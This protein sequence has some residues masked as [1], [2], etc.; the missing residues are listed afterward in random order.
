VFRTIVRLVGHVVAILVAVT[1]FSAA[2]QTSLFIVESEMVVGALLS[3]G[4]GGERLKG[5]IAGSFNLNLVG[6]G[7]LARSRLKRPAD[8]RGLE[9]QQGSFRNGEAEGGRIRKNRAAGRGEVEALGKIDFSANHHGAVLLGMARDRLKGHATAAGTSGGLRGFSQAK[10]GD[11]QQSFSIQGKRGAILQSGAL[12]GSQLARDGKT[13]VF[14]HPACQQRG[15]F[16]GIAGSAVGRG[17]ILSVAAGSAQPSQQ[18]K[19]RKN[20]PKPINPFGISHEAPYPQGSCRV[21]G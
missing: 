16:F 2:L 3:H 19:N 13:Q 17:R 18:K 1:A 4:L 21:V 14:Q 6:I 7:S 12:P 15:L 11:I 20:S 8:R 9:A 5:E 10:C